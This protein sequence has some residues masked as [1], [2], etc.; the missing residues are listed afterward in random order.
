MICWESMKKEENYS[1]KNTENHFQWKREKVKNLSFHFII[2]YSAIVE[3]I[4]ELRK[5]LEISKIS[6]T[7]GSNIIR[8][9]REKLFEESYNQFMTMEH[10]KVNHSILIFCLGTQSCV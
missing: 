9:D 8:I 6:F 7:Q 3:K 5:K 2:S 1:M 10:Q 4:D